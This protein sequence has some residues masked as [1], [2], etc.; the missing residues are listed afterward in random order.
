MLQSYKMCVE[1]TDFGVKRA[2]QYPSFQLGN[3]EDHWVA[4]WLASG[5]GST[6]SHCVT[7]RRVGC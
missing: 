6:H 7:I 4:S 2:Q 1:E 3:Q 5:K